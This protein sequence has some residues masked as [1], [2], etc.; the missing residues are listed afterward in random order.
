MRLGDAVETITVVRPVILEVPVL[1]S[2]GVE[3]VPV[4]EPVY[5]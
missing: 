4:Q 3:Q 1:E 2:P 5:V